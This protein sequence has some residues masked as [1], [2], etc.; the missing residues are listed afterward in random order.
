MRQ[1]NV[2]E[3]IVALAPTFRSA[4][5]ITQHRG[6]YCFAVTSGQQRQHP[7]FLAFQASEPARTVGRD[8]HG[9]GSQYESLR[10]EVQHWFDGNSAL[11]RAP[12]VT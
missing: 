5:D 1:M 8:Q 4:L 6:R 7:R 10:R 3:A 2:S 12:L 9:T 11:P